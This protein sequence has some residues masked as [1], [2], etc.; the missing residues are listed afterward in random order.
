MDDTGNRAWAGMPP[1]DRFVFILGMIRD[2]HP[3]VSNKSKSKRKLCHLGQHPQCLRWLLRENIESDPVGSNNVGN[4][5]LALEKKGLITR[6]KN[7]DTLIFGKEQVL[8]E[9]NSKIPNL[10]DRGYEHYSDIVKQQTLNLELLPD[11]FL[12]ICLDENILLP[13]KSVNHYP[14]P[15]SIRDF[16]PI[17]GNTIEINEINHK[18]PIRNKFLL[19]NILNFSYDDLSRLLREERG[20]H[21]LIGG[22][23]SGKTQILQAAAKTWFMPHVAY[24]DSAIVHTTFS[25]RKY[26]EYLIERETP[27]EDEEELELWCSRDSRHFPPEPDT[28]DDKEWEDYERKRTRINL[29]LTVKVLENYIFENYV[30][31]LPNTT[32]KETPLRMLREAKPK[33]A[34]FADGLDE[35]SNEYRNRILTQFNLLVET[36]PSHRILIATRP[37]Q[38][39]EQFQPELQTSIQLVELPVNWPSKDPSL[40]LEYWPK[41]LGRTP[42][43][44]MLVRETHGKTSEGAGETEILDQYL[45]DCMEKALKKEQP[46]LMKKKMWDILRKTAL[47]HSEIGMREFCEIPGGIDDEDGIKDWNKTTTWAYLNMQ[48]IQEVPGWRISGFEHMTVAEET[49]QF[50]HRRIQEYLASQFFNNLEDFFEWF[51]HQKMQN[52]N[53]CWPVVRDVMLRYNAKNKIIQYLKDLDEDIL[54]HREGLINYLNEENNQLLPKGIPKNHTKVEMKTTLN[55]IGDD[56]FHEYP[57]SVSEESIQKAESIIQVL[58]TIEEHGQSESSELGVNWEKSF[59]L[60]PTFLQSFT[61]RLLERENRKMIRNINATQPERSLRFWEYYTKLLWISKKP[62]AKELGEFVKPLEKR[63][64]KY[65]WNLEEWIKPWKKARSFN[66]LDLD[67]K[68]DVLFETFKM[69]KENPIPFEGPEQQLVH[70]LDS[71]GLSVY[72]VEI[73]W[74]FGLTPLTFTFNHWL[75][76]FNLDSHQ[77]VNHDNDYSLQALGWILTLCREF[78]VRVILYDGPRTRI[79]HPRFKNQKLSSTIPNAPNSPTEILDMIENPAPVIGKITINASASRFELKEM[80]VAAEKSN[81]TEL[82]KQWLFKKPDFYFEPEET[83]GSPTGV[84]SNLYRNQFLEHW[85]LS[86][87]LQGDLPLLKEYPWFEE[88]WG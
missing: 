55:K 47:L 83:S 37:I 71:L 86:P 59:G 33:L 79:R 26:A 14:L 16:Q 4:W 44:W 31:Q 48:I 38:T 34:I 45:D 78:R 1:S 85:C 6:E 46:P 62:V 52:P 74:M 69:N 49:Y 35:I 77:K 12:F 80:L 10:T 70:F 23:G 56:S 8:G 15:V 13:V 25:C 5:A 36:N 88:L 28:I 42:L 76:V 87:Y 24:N 67:T 39:P 84:L 41:G 81:R 27:P 7:E 82:L 30:Q 68:N 72:S 17:N 20:I 9:T 32:S 57:Q 66:L 11:W 54:G 18:E 43:T 2:K 73:S 40:E 61:L 60:E 75:R 21:M 58:R 65:N 53:W 22:T 50:S 19:N 64:M 3:S 63:F 51:D 29:E